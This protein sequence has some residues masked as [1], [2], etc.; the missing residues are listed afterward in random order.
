MGRVALSEPRKTV[1]MKPELAEGSEGRLVEVRAGERQAGAMR[2]EEREGFIDLVRGFALFGILFV[3]LP[4]MSNPYVSLMPGLDGWTGGVDQVAK[5]VKVFFF[6]G[7]FYVIFALLFGY[8][9]EVLRRRRE[10]VGA[11]GGSYGRRLAGLALAGGLHLGLLWYGDVLLLYAGCGV[12]LWWM[13]KG[14]DRGFLGWAVAGLVLPSVVMGVMVGMTT[15]M[16]VDAGEWEADWRVANEQV[17]WA[18]GQGS[19]ADV[20]AMRWWE[21]EFALNSLLVFGP[22]VLT[23]MV[24]GVWA[25]R[26]GWLE[27]VGERAVVY[28]RLWWV[29]LPLGVLG[30]GIYVWAGWQMTIV[31]DGWS[32]WFV[33]ASSVG[34]P[35]MAVVYLCGWRQ[36]YLAGWGAGLSRRMMAAGRMPLTNYL[37][38]SLVATTLFYSYGAGLYGQVSHWQNACLAVGI[39]GLQLGVSGWWL[40]RFERGPLEA[41]WKWV[42]HGR[43]KGAEG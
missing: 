18:Y 26:R 19:F 16:G 2:T 36:A 37:G 15:A 43:V 6:E 12:V 4:M 25:A 14:S 21:Y 31:P 23:A 30:K 5:G 3:N 27:R 1:N 41:G 17:A 7:S 11:G 40:A 8:G 28:R 34:G 35:A 33:A 22:Q 20:V 42:S 29:C 38:Q 32:L 10:K 13:R 24:L 9:F 39:Y